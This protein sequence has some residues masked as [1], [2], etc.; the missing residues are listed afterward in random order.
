MNSEGQGAPSAQKGIKARRVPFAPTLNA[1]FRDP[2]TDYPNMNWAAPSNNGGEAITGYKVYRSTTSGTLGTLVQTTNATTTEFLDTTALWGTTYYYT[3]KATNVMGN[4][5]SSTQRSY[6]AYTKPGSLTILSF[7]YEQDG[8]IR[9]NWEAP[10]FDG[11]EAITSYNLYRSET[12]GVQGSLLTSTDATPILDTT[13]IPGTVYYYTVRAVNPAGEGSASAQE[14]KKAGCPPSA[15]Y[16][17]DLTIT[18]EGYP[19]INWSN[20]QYHGGFPITAFRIYRSET[21]GV[22][23]ALLTELDSSIFVHTD[24]TANIGTVYYYMVSAVNSEGEGA[25]S[26]QKSI[27]PSVAPGAP[28][29]QVPI[30]TPMGLPYLEWTEPLFDGGEPIQAYR[31]YRSTSMGE[32]GDPLVILNATVK[33]Y[34]D[35]NV[36]MGITYYYVVKAENVRGIGNASVQQSIK[37]G[38]VPTEPRNLTLSHTSR[39]HTLKLGSTR[40]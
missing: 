4:G 28:D 16:L 14:S 5:D 31:I 34:T 26:Q 33:N 40:I 8:L 17:W 11:G 24:T 23:G 32:E 35:G 36:S 13:V 6:K 21:P 30:H 10:T 18:G 37:A 3:V 19:I 2:S 20:P 38:T 22:Q 9:I 15:P 12:P 7:S 39:F 29:L 25:L 1:Q 27:Y